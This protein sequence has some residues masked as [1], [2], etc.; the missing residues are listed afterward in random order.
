MKNRRP[1]INESLTKSVQ[2]YANSH[3]DGNFT[4]AINHLAAGALSTLGMLDEMY[5]NG[6]L[7]REYRGVFGRLMN[8]EFRQAQR[9][10]NLQAAEIMENSVAGPQRYPFDRQLDDNSR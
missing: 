2:K 1:K 5:P 3:F 6:E 10:K 8:E 7:E 4:K 9:L